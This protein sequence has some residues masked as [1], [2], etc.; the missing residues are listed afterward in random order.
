MQPK[1]TTDFVEPFKKMRTPFRVFMNGFEPSKL[2]VQ[3]SG[4]SIGPGAHDSITSIPKF[5]HYFKNVNL[6]VFDRFPKS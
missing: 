1:F 5:Y 4:T 6:R 2:G 3:L